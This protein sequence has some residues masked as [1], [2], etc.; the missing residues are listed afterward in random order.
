MIKFRPDLHSWTTSHTSPLW[1]SYGRL[2]WV[3]RRKVTAIYKERIVLVLPKYSMSLLGNKHCNRAATRGSIWCCYR[4]K[5]EGLLKQGKRWDNNLIISLE[6]YFFIVCNVM[7]IL[8]DISRMKMLSESDKHGGC[9]WS[10]AYLTSK[11]FRASMWRR[12]AGRCIFCNS[13]LSGMI[14]SLI[15]KYTTEILVSLMMRY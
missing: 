9:W 5:K 1:A 4:C 3:I 13:L 12:T 10:G 8:R 14:S 15:P 6:Y 2:S 7:F 11:Q